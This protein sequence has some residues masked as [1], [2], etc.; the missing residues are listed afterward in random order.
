MATEQ[1]GSGDD[2]ERGRLA[3]P[4][5][6]SPMHFDKYRSHVPLVLS[7]R[8]WP[9]RQFTRAP[10][11]ASV[12]L[13]DGNQAL[14]DPMDSERK[15]AL[16]QTLLAVG[17]KEIEV[18]FPSASQ[19]DYDFQ[20]LI[21]DDGLIPDD[22][23]IQVLVQCREELIERTFE[24]LTG[25]RHAVVHFYN[26]VS[27]LQRRVV[28]GLDKAGIVDIAVN[29]A[30]LC[31]KFEQFVPD[32]QIRYEYSPESFTG[33]EPEFAVEI[34]EAVMDVIEPTPER[35]MILNLPATV[36]MYSPN[37]YADVIE[38]FG[39]TIKNRDAIVLSLHPHNDR[40][41]AVAAAEL[42]VL[43]GADRVE[44]TLF[45]NG[46]RTGNVDIVTLAMNLFS[47][48]IEPA[49]DFG[50]I[51]KV[52]RVA[53]YA[54]RLPVHPRHP[55]AGDLVYTAFS[56]SHQDAI[57]KGMSAIG[58]DYEEWEVPYL[59]IDPKH[60]GRTYEAI[61][62]VNSQSGKGGVAYL[63]DT[64][65]GLDLPRRLQVEFSKTVQAITEASGTVIGSGEMWNVFSAAYLAEDAGLRLVGSEVSTGGGHT[66]VTAQLLVDG[67]HRT[68]AGEGNGPID[69]LVAAV[70]AE[71][72]IVLEVKD[73]SEHALTEGSGASAVAYVECAGPDG[74]TWWGVGRDSSILD[75]SLAAVVSAAN[76][77]RTG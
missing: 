31:R 41:T 57:K 58:E 72:G 50:D 62:Q 65:H 54:T 29:A 17:F 38:W 51:E 24:S 2:G 46:E 32:T 47:Q 34:C 35:P 66:S 48:G 40:G 30:R 63:M 56:G 55:Y 74:S 36:E 33:T 22:V 59:P 9:D 12:D 16:F 19:T 44:G 28:F 15:L 75:A 21:I 1:K 26:S 10:R 14:I 42:A 20:R 18:G 73:Y 45:G 71:L 60:T 7:D 77:A 27:A 70:R 25:A 4:C 37:V 61:I 23:E 11:W 69:A 68:I 13:R 5:D 49:L 67:Q 3:L 76:R 43:A 39:R 53:E 64:E 8:T 52:R 6:P